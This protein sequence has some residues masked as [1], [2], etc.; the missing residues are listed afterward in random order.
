MHHLPDMRSQLLFFIFTM[1][2]VENLNYGGWELFLTLF[3]PEE[4]GNV[5]HALSATRVGRCF[6]RSLGHKNYKSL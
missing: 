6:P 3:G 5:S 1:D 2:Q 4:L